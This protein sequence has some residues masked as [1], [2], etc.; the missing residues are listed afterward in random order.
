MRNGDV[1]Y[2]SVLVSRFI[3]YLMRRG[4]KSTAQKIFY[5]ALSRLSP[6]KNESFELMKRAV[7]AVM[8]RMEVRPRRIGG[9]TYQVPVQLRRERSETL[10]LRWLILAAREKRGRPMEEKLAGEIKEVLEG[11]GAAVKRKETAHRMA[12][13]NKA[14][15]HFRW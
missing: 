1:I 12:E 9:A 13:A 14:F 4:K 3:N 15:A 6:D 8:P 2:N 7:E 11:T 5:G 10:A